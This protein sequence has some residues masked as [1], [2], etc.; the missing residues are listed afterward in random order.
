MKF[1][2][3]LPISLMFLSIS[4]TAHADE[5]GRHPSYIHALSDLGAA[6][7]MVTH[8]RPEDGAIG[9]EERN[10]IEEIGAAY[11]EIEQSAIKDG[12][13][14]DRHMAQDRVIET[15]GRMHNALALLQKAHD[16]VAR[17]EDDASTQGLQ[18][19]ALRHIDAAIRLAE[20][21]ITQADPH[22]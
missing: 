12:K 5:P 20:R 3:F 9:A 13:P 19:R 22:R 14:I 11:K 2:K 8:R 10:M 15:N 6:N 21:V 4:F 18:D 1:Q 17:E 16:D 7:W